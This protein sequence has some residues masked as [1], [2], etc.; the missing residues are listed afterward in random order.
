MNIWQTQV[1]YKVT[2]KK[3]L[4]HEKNYELFKR[5]EKE[6][7]DPQLRSDKENKTL[8][9]QIRRLEQENDDIA[10][11]F[12]NYQV[13]LN[14]KYDELK[15]KNEVM[16]LELNK[17][18]Q[19]QQFKYSDYNDTISKYQAE[20]ENIKSLYR[21]NIDNYEYS[22]KQREIVKQVNQR[23]SRKLADFKIETKRELDKL[24]GQIESLNVNPVNDA[25]QESIQ[26]FMQ[27]HIY[28]DTSDVSKEYSG[29]SKGSHV[30]T[31]VND[32]DRIRDLELQLASAKLELVNEKCLNQE[33][34]HKMKQLSTH[35]NEML[36]NSTNR[37][38]NKT[39]NQ[40]KDATSHVVQK[41]NK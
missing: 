17:L 37:W 18:K 16:E 4:K 30:E 24:F 39:L 35:T 40:F 3:I 36:T 28:L 41:A 27:G 25:V 22:L 23:L 12:I 2:N 26:A 31:T 13:D 21:S 8:Q 14:K 9:Q 7:E 5:L 34:I 10:N 11:E 33:N 15:D 1:H 29:E 38:F 20:L 6:K 32:E 19:D